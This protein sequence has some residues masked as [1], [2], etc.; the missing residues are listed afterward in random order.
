MERSVTEY[1]VS[2][3]VAG[4]TLDKYNIVYSNSKDLEAL[5]A[6]RD[7]IAKNSGYVM[8]IVLDTQ[9]EPSKYEI[10]FG[11]TNRAESSMIE[12][13]DS[14]NYTIRVVDEKLVEVVAYRR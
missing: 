6:F 4:N 1:P 14:L 11:E 7:K 10:L 2:V 13:P 9:T 12:T 5:E 3:T 8:D